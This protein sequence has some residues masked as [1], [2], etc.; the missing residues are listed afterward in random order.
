MCNP[1]WFYTIDKN[2]KPPYDSMPH[3]TGRT[4]SRG[5]GKVSTEKTNE[6]RKMVYISNKISNS[7]L[8]SEHF[9]CYKD[10]TEINE[11]LGKYIVP[12][13]KIDIL[14]YVGKI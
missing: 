2:N 14:G 6:L 9:E 5:D 11:I 8:R 4:I 1:I 3:A 12:Q 7:S 10:Y 13:G